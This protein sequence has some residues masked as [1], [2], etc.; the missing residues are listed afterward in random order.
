MKE[1]SNELKQ[2][3]FENL[4]ETID[5]QD[6]KLKEFR[7][8]LDK[9]DN[10]LNGLI[11]DEIVIRFLRARKFDI[12]LSYQTF[13][14]WIEFK[15]THF[16]SFNN[17]HAKEFESFNHLYRILP[18]P[19]SEGRLICIIPAYHSLRIFTTEYLSKN[20]NGMSRAHYWFVEKISMDLN[21]QVNGIVAILD[22][23]NMTLWD[24]V[25]MSRLLNIS[26]QLNLI[27]FLQDC[28]GLRLKAVYFFNEPTYITCL[29]FCMRPLLTSE[30]VSRFHFCQQNY[31]LLYDILPNYNGGGVEEGE[32]NWVLEQIKAEDIAAFLI[33]QV[34]I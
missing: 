6:K 25:S 28:I 5:L 29:W 18:N 12:N 3:A 11:S 1:L 34:L 26:D 16:D 7:T 30:M 24:H 17:L 22:F 33:N 20:P 21:A 2:R 4:G 23:G 8:K 19:D 27:R 13:V 32:V 31:D 9:L 14:N 10:H 15:K